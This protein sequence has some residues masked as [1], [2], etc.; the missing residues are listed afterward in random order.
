MP[1][2]RLDGSCTDPDAARLRAVRA[3]DVRADGQDL[4][5]QDRAQQAVE[6]GA[7]DA[8]EGRT[9][10][11]FECGTAH[12]G[13]PGAV[14]RTGTSGVPAAGGADGGPDAERVEGAM[15]LAAS[16]IP[17]PAS[18]RTGVGSTTAVTSEPTR[19][20]PMAAASPLMPP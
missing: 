12:P 14:R 13:E 20:S 16:E 10:G 17:A 1:G 11:A 5:R 8:D 4:G 18:P 15:P 9:E 6:R 7:R 19:R 2:P 3:G